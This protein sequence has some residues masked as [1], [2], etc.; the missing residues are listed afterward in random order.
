MAG[1]LCIE[2]KLKGSKSGAGHGFMTGSLPPLSI[3]GI[4]RRRCP[5]FA[6]CRAIS[7]GCTTSIGSV[8]AVSTIQAIRTRFGPVI[9]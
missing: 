7:R 6:S 2:R 3:V 5:P 8:F 1:P 4:F 9:H